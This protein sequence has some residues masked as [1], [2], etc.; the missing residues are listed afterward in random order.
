MIRPSTRRAYSVRR[1]P[2][3]R[4]DAVAEVNVLSNFQPEYGRNAGA[5]INIVT[6]SGAN[7][8]HGTAGEYIRNDALDARNYFNPSQASPRLRSTTTSSAPPWA[9]RSSRDKTFFYVDYE[10]QQEPVGVV[11]ISKRPHRQ[12]RGRIAATQRRHQSGDC[13]SS[14]AT[15]LAGAKSRPTQGGFPMPASPRSSRPLTTISPASLPRS[16]RISTPA[17]SSPAAISLATACSRS[18]SP[19]PPSGGQLPGFNTFTPTR[20]QLASLSYVHTFGANKV[21]ELRYGW[22]RF[23]EGFF[24]D[25][26]SFHPSSIG[27][28]ARNHRRRRL[29]RSGSHRSGP[30]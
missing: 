11:T 13:R 21:N 12:R 9:D 14:S 16:T 27:L 24:P 10:G 17:I 1:Q 20:V 3:C 8:I 30:A 23:A 4:I 15:S 22:N 26:Q 19:S 2:S 29:Q 7:K 28:C 18:R 5:V 25:D 6:K